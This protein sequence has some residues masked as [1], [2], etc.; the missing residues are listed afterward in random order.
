KHQLLNRDGVLS[1][2]YDTAVFADIAG[3]RNLKVWLEQRRLAFTRSRP[4]GLDPP[5]GLLLIGVQGCGKSVAAKAAAGVFGVPLLSLDIGALYNKYHGETERNVRS[6]LA[7][8]D[9][10]SP[11]VL[12]IDEMEKGLATGMDDSGTSRRL[13]ASLLTWMAERRSETLIVATSN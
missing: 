8:A 11:C 2:E 10:M 5:K 6:A 13:L 9:L 7:T 12:W 3:F 4:P 1:Y